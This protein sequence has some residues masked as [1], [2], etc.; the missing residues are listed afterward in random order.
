FLS[1]IFIPLVYNW[2]VREKQADGERES[3]SELFLKNIKL[4]LSPERAKKRE[5]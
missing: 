4:T 5:T 3:K 1:L 2:V